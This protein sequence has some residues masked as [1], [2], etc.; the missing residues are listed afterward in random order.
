LEGTACSSP[1]LELA[2]FLLVVITV[3]WALRS[4]R[5]AHKL[6]LLAASYFFCSRLHWGFAAMLLASSLANWAFGEAISRAGRPSSRRGWLLGALAINL[7]VLGAFKYYGF[8]SESVG[9]LVALM[10]L[11]AHLPVIELLLPALLLHLPGPGL[12][13][14]PLPRP[15]AAGAL[16]F[17]LF[18]GFFPKLVSGPIRVTSLSRLKSVAP[19]KPVTR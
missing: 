18:M 12:R 15:R 8:F 3:S 9:D 14:R 4:Q 10:G 17:L 2:Y 11:E 7:G 5:T 19:R 16:D 6:F 1:R 13:L